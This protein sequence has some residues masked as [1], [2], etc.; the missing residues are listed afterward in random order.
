MNAGLISTIVG[1]IVSVLL[2]TIP[3]LKEVWVN[4]KWKRVVLLAGFVLVPIATWLLICPA[5]LDVGVVADCT[6]QG[7]LEWAVI[8]LMAFTGSQTTYLLGVQK[9]AVRYDPIH[10]QPK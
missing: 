10:E 3:G 5:G 6:T 9:L 8:G 7:L 1:M 4:W 2:E